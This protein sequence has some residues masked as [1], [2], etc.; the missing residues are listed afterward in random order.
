MTLRHSVFRARFRPKDGRMKQNGGH[1]A[2]LRQKLPLE[3]DLPTFL[4]TL[5]FW[6]VT[7][8]TRRLHIGYI[9]KLRN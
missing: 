1:H 9:G 6:A 8:V 2:I 3:S 7:S 5:H 4:V